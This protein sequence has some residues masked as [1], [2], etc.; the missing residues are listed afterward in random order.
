MCIRDRDIVGHGYLILSGED[1]GE[2]NDVGGSKTVIAVL[3]D[4]AGD[5][6]YDEIFAGMEIGNFYAVD[7]E[8]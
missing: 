1:F 6:V 5:P 8:G 3:C 7:F 2:I 4:L